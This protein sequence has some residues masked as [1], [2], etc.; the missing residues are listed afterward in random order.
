MQIREADHTDTDAV[1][2]IFSR[3]VQTGN[4]YVYPPDTSKEQFPELWFAPGMKTWVAEEK[5]EIVGTYFIKP[6]QIGLGSHIAN[7]GYMV[8]PA[9][10]GRGVGK[11]MCEHSLATAKELGFRAMQFNL[12]VSTNEVAIRLWKKF[13]FR[14]IGTIPDGFNHAELGYVDACIMYREI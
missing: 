9:A 4:T 3:V 12:V 2:E 1:W 7:C 8:H 13:G 14:I 10:Q 11:Q 5:D 6:N